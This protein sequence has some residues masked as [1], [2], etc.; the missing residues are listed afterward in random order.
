MSVALRTT[1][2]G[3]TVDL[4]LLAAQATVAAKQD[5]AKG[6]AVYDAAEIDAMVAYLQGLK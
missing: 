5:A 3:T 1:M 4:L 2:I 6:Q